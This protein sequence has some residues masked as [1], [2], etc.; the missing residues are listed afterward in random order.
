MTMDAREAAYKAQYD[1]ELALLADAKANGF[2]NCVDIVKAM[3]WEGIRWQAAF[4][5]ADE[6]GE[7]IVILI[8]DG[9]TGNRKY[10]IPVSR[11]KGV[12]RDA[13]E[14]IRQCRE[15]TE[16]KRRWDEY[17]QNY[18]AMLVCDVPVD[19]ILHVIGNTPPAPDPLVLE[20]A[21]TRRAERNEAKT[22]ELRTHLP[23]KNG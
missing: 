16:T 5:Q 23:R 3:G 15:A 4:H 21:A 11:R 9:H 20:V 14:R 10:K 17:H 1:A 2:M 13:F 8:P 12:Y 18:D 7:D 22:T 6:A 19:Q